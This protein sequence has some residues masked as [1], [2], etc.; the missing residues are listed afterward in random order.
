MT[1]KK[2]RTRP[3]ETIEPRIESLVTPAAV[4]AQ[5]GIEFPAPLLTIE[6]LPASTW[7]S[8]LRSALRPS[9]WN[10]LRRAAY[11]AADN[12]CEVCQGVGHQYR[13]AG[14]ELWMFDDLACIQKLIRV[15]A[16]CPECHDVK[17]FGRAQEQGRGPDVIMR[18]VEVNDWSIANAR[19]YGELHLRLW[20]LRTEKHWQIDLS[21]LAQ[22][23]I[24]PK[25]QGEGEHLDR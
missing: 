5:I 24:T 1:R 4:L 22:F 17:H 16:L 12:K 15:I 8:N 20:R 19:R 9:D 7:G 11:A 25:E 10:K 21:W 2:P 23:N 18:L 6:L 3:A 13:V 14:H